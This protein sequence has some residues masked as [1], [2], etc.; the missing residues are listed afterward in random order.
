MQYNITP[1]SL[2][3][4]QF[5]CMGLRP[6]VHRSSIHESA[7]NQGIQ[8]SMITSTI[9]SVRTPSMG[10]RTQSALCCARA[11]IGIAFALQ[12]F[13]RRGCFQSGSSHL[14]VKRSKSHLVWVLAKISNDSKANTKKHVLL[15]LWVEQVMC[16]CFTPSDINHTTHGPS[17]L[18]A[19]AGDASPLP[20]AE[21]KKE[22]KDC[23]NDT[24]P[25]AFE[26]NLKVWMT[27]EDLFTHA[28]LLEKNF[29]SCTLHSW[30]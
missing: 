19:S 24:R 23:S 29:R 17:S 3:G 10:T 12:K 11:M 20:L 26:D 8:C 7:K 1:S 28:A 2:H 9:A 15:F 4:V 25:R 21:P 18:E 22:K 30:V 27:R 13:L 6:I 16:D 14:S 5:V